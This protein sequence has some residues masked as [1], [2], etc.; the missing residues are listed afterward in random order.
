MR[1]RISAGGATGCQGYESKQK[2]QLVPV[3]QVLSPYPLNF[4]PQREFRSAV[5]NRK[6]ATGIATGLI[7]LGRDKRGTIGMPGAEYTNKTIE[8]RTKKDRAGR[9]SADYEP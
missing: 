5:F 8:K 2:R 6:I 3:D 4:H 7:N 9:G 1:G